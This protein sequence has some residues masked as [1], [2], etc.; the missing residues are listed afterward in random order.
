MPLITVLMPMYNGERFLRPAMDSILS[1]SFGDFELLVLD[2][3]SKDASVEIARS[4]RDDRIRLFPLEHLGLIATLNF[5]LKEARGEWIARMDCD[6]VALCDRLQRQWDYLCNHKDLVVLGGAVELIDAEGRRM[7][8]KPTPPQ[9]HEAIVGNMTFRRNGPALIHPTVFVRTDAARQVGGYRIQFPVAEDADFWLRLSC[10]GQIASLQEPVLL[11]RKHGENVSAVKYQVSTE[12]SL[13]AAVCQIIRER[14]GKDPIEAAPKAWAEC[15][16][17]IHEEVEGSG[18]MR[19]K[20]ARQTF[21]DRLRSRSLSA[22]AA[23]LGSLVLH[24]SDVRF[25]WCREVCRKIVMKCSDRLF[26]AMGKREA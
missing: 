25:L 13:A 8:A 23:A 17:H 6:D 4:Y 12:S 24:P 9:D 22:A 18:L 3:G 2:D 15:Q 19:L 10:V 1:Q 14:S 16:T 7:G 20:C 26:R 5:G 11:L 21:V